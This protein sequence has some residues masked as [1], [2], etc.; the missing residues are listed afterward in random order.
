M[1][2]GGRDL[3]SSIPHPQFPTNFN[4]SIEMDMVEEMSECLSTWKR[5]R[6]ELRKF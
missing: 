5:E 2:L 1:I 4:N 6:K 3:T